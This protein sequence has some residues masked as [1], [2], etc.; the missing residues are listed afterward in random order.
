M[1]R[2]DQAVQAGEDVQDHGETTGKGHPLNN[3]SWALAKTNTQH[4][5]IWA[6]DPRCAA[7]GIGVYAHDEACNWIV[8][9]RAHS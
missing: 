8:G 4:G 6:W 7:Y 5:P 2:P 3:N 9:A 1:K